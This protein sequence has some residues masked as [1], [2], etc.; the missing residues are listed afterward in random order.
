MGEIT[1]SQRIE[2]FR[3]QAA[4][5]NEMAVRAQ[6]EADFLR[7]QCND[8]TQQATLADRTVT[9]ADFARR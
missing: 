9:A 7:A 4:Q 1:T 3:N 6:L 5:A 2:A 8:L